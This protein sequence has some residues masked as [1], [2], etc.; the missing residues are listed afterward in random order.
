MGVISWVILGLI[1]GYLAKW[2]MPGRDPGG[3]IITMLIGI[4]GGV[5]GG[6]VATGLGLGKM[7]GIGLY[8]ILLAVAG[9]LVLLIG[10]RLLRPQAKT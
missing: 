5:I 7:D 3:L 4:A 1:A 10:F 8:S 2:I 9:A 6:F